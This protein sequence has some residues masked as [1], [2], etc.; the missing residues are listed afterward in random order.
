[1]TAEA[2]GRPPAE[3][4]VAPMPDSVDGVWGAF[5]SLANTRGSSG[6]GPC[7]ISLSEIDA[8]QRLNHCTLT[9]WEIDTLLA[10]DQAWL[11]DY[12]I[13]AKRNAKQ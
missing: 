12:A 4:A 6:F 10:L 2:T 9:P 8:W 1:M 13:T 7:A 3:L 11:A 5:I